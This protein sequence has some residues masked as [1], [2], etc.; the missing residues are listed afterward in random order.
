MR[1]I[2]PY[3]MK[4]IYAI[5]HQLSLV[6]HDHEDELHALVATI[7]GKESVK[8]LSYREAESVIA[9]L[10]QLQG[11]QA[12]PRPRREREHPSRPGGVTSGQDFQMAGYILDN[13]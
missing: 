5:G 13:G 10:T 11:G 12:P 3:Q 6:G 9:R 1:S 7:T 2:D 8:A 4:R